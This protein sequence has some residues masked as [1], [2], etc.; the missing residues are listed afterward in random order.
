M[1]PRFIFTFHFSLFTM[2][3]VFCGT[4][5]FAVPTLEKLAASFDVNLVVTQPDRPSVRGMDVIAPPVKRLA[6][7]L[8]IPV[9]QP[10]KIKSN[11]DFRAQ[12]EALKPDAIA[13]VAYGRIIPQ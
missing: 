7:R 13:V 9:T 1:L 3:L 2:N 10:D 12:L 4:P 8:G 6:T 5:E 11:A